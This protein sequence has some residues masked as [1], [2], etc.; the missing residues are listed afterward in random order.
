[1]PKV[2]ATVE[3]NGLQVGFWKWSP[4]DPKLTLIKYLVQHAHIPIPKAQVFI[5]FALWAK[6][7]QLYKSKFFK[8]CTKATDLYCPWDIESQN[9]WYTCV[10]IYHQDPDP[11]TLISPIF[12]NSALL[13]INWV[14]K[15]RIENMHHLKAKIHLKILEIKSTCCIHIKL[16]SPEYKVKTAKLEYIVYTYWQCLRFFFSVSLLLQVTV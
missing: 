12:I 4:N 14:I 5:Y 11:G 1:M 3:I 16:N 7:F 13:V 10:N 9:Y 6:A 15:S 2:L 8:Q